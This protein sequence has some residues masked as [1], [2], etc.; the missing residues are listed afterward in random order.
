MDAAL[1]RNLG[2]VRVRLESK[3]LQNRRLREDVD[4]ATIQKVVHL[5]TTGHV[6]VRRYNAAQ[7]TALLNDDLD[8]GIDLQGP[9]GQAQVTIRLSES[10]YIGSYSFNPSRI[11]AKNLRE[12][13]TEM[14]AVLKV[15]EQA[16]ALVK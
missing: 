11:T 10:G 6:K 5:L 4:A 9:S 2:R 8:H 1:V 16:W 13:L 3:G 15:A 7:L 14:D 12:A